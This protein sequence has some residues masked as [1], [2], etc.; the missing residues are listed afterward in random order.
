MVKE[1]QIHSEHITAGKRS[2]SLQVK[3]SK[4]KSKY[5]LITECN[6]SAGEKVEL[7]NIVI[8]EE[9][10]DKFTDGL[11]KMLILFQ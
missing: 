6:V 8:Y 2:Y 3:R 4:D 1:K 10:M 11:I 9:D 7:R 5:L